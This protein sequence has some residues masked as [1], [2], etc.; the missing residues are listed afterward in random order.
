MVNH[1]QSN[2]LAV[3][4]WQ[5]NRPVVIVSTNCDP[6]QTTTVRHDNNGTS[7]SIPCPMSVYLYN[8]YMGGLDHNDQ[9][10][11]YYNVRLKGFYKYIFFVSF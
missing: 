3:S 10:R 4:L 6:S 5:D 2:R 1:K 9:L 8:K 7:N 11:G